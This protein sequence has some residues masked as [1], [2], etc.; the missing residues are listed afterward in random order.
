MQSARH[1]LTVLLLFGLLASGLPL[2]SAEDANRDNR[3]DLADAILCIRDFVRTAE[4]PGSFAFE[5]ETVFTVLNHVAGLK[6]SIRPASEEKSKP[7]SLTLSGFYLVSS[8]DKPFRVDNSFL[9]AEQ[10]VHHESLSLEP[11]TPPPKRA[12]S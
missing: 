2:K 6:R 9:L 4:E 8:V 11:T 5:V 12:A 3:V 10:G 1:I 7:V